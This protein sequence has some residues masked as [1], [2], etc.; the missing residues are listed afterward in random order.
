MINLVGN[1]V[2]FT[3]EGEVTI[4]ISLQEENSS[5]A[6]IRFGVRDTG[7]GI[8]KK[9]IA[10]LFK[11]FTQ[12]DSS[13]TRKF[14]GT[15][16]G[17]TISKRLC[18]L[19]GG[20]IKIESEEGK[21]SEFWF[22]VIFEKQLGTKNKT[23][24]MPGKIR[25]KRIL[26]VDNNNTNR[27]ALTEQLK[28]WGCRYDSVPDGNKALT[29]LN[30]AAVDNNPFNIAIINMQMP[31]MDG[32]SVGKKIKKDPNLQNTILVMMTSMGA[33][34][35]K[36]RFEKIGFVAYLSKP[37]KQSYLYDCLTTVIGTDST[38]AKRE[39]QIVTKY[40][41]SENH[42]LKYKILLAEDNIINQKVAFLTLKKLGYKVDT[43]NDGK[44]AVNAL[45][46]TRYDLV[47]MDCQMPKMDGFLATGQIRD[48]ESKVLDHN[49]PIIA[50][51]ANATKADEMKCL[52]AGMDD[53]MSKPFDVEVLSTL[54]VKW[55]SARHDERK[56]FLIKKNQ[57]NDNSF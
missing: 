6:T 17:L 31:Q 37:V 4:D 43:V 12:A 47:L 55:L 33:K 39:G 3:E 36:K 1:A 50:L 56:S 25:G 40:T 54:L 18:E 21:G 42:N 26:I 15:G 34:G 35:D 24:V 38:E 52:N 16:L 27:Y 5:K 22:T 49:I 53:F 11:S 8:P 41:L 9:S 29:K 51:T 30:Q 45:E 10:T 13:T 20:Q 57:S 19:M 7:I 48:P 2:K 46:K 44:Q 28:I 14:G 23:V 32:A